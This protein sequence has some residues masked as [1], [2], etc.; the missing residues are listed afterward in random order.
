MRRRRPGHRVLARFVGLGQIDT[1]AS[2]D[3][4][5]LRIILRKQTPSGKEKFFNN[6]FFA[7]S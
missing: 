1:L 5:G 3:I 4:R 2:S 7:S 6:G